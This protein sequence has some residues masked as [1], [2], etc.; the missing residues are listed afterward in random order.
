MKRLL[1]LALLLVAPCFAQELA[2]IHRDVHG[3]V[4]TVDTHEDGETILGLELCNDKHGMECVTIST[5]GREWISGIA[6]VVEDN[7]I[8]ARVTAYVR[9]NGET[10]IFLERVWAEDEYFGRKK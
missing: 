5:E 9:P 7:M 6:E 10:E 4:Y 3:Y 2:P 1:I 8:V